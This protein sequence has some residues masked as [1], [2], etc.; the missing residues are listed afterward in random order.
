MRRKDSFA[1][2]AQ[3]QYDNI[4]ACILFIGRTVRP[5]LLFGGTSRFGSASP[6]WTLDDLQSQPKHKPSVTTLQ[7]VVGI[8]ML[9]ARS[10]HSSVRDRPNRSSFRL[11]FTEPIFHLTWKVIPVAL[12]RNG[13]LETHSTHISRF[14][15]RLMKRLW[16]D[17]IRC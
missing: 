13:A 17:P 12:T 10:K 1:C 7:R 8:I 14:R 15:M 4:G 6:T 2:L 5:Y 9:V 3:Q 11:L 16:M